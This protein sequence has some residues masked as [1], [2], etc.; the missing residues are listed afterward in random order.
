[1]SSK[2]ISLLEYPN[3][4]LY[5]RVSDRKVQQLVQKCDLYLDINSLKESRFSDRVSHLGKPIFSFASVTRPNN[6]PNYRMFAD[7]DIHGMVKAIN[8]IFNG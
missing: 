8:E 7:N 2:L 4:R 1:M 6:H 5:S 3:V